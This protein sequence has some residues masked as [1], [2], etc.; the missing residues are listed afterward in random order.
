[1]EKVSFDLKTEIQI[2]PNRLLNFA[3]ELGIRLIRNGA[4]MYRVEES[5]KHILNAYG[6]DQ[7]EIFSIPAL[8]L[9]NF[10]IGDENFTKL[11]RVKGAVNNLERLNQLNALCRKICKEQ[12]PL[13]QAETEL[14]DIA[15]RPLYPMLVSYLAYGAA[16]FFFALF[17]G[18]TLIDAIIALITGFI[19]KFTVGFSSKLKTNLFFANVLSGC[20]LA[21]LP[22]LLNFAFP[23]FVHLDKIIIGV[24]M[25]LVPGI[26]IAN[27]MRDVLAG[28][29][30][31][32]L[33]K[34]TEVLIIG[35][36]IAIG[37]AIPMTL[38][39]M[40]LNTLL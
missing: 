15:H 10:E 34:F 7:M 40:M 2:N 12:I 1:M 22:I 16:A 28:D 6:I 33:T 24:I 14:R 18:A 32:A 8:V 5:V 39:K 11:V 20:C 17:W 27:V 36:G 23:D 31:T 4:E 9:I 35:A 26:A 13:E 37:I 29:T 30:L 21:V 19:V 3:C 38:F 25:L